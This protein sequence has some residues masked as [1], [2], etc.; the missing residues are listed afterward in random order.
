M[1]NRTLYILFNLFLVA[2]FLFSVACSDEKDDLLT[3]T[4]PEEPPA[5]T[6]RTLKITINYTGNS[7]GELLMELT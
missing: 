7:N 4:P 3:P 6:K 1:I 5:S 2:I